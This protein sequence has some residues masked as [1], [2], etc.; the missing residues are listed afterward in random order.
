MSQFSSIKCSVQEGVGQLELARPAKS[1][2]INRDMWT[3]LGPGLQ[4]LVDHGA[5]AVRTRATI[6]GA[7][8]GARRSRQLPP[9]IRSVL[10]C[11]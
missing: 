4:W 3:E 9:P 7:H 2:S 11:R 1:N 8:G 10:A 5:R 6:H